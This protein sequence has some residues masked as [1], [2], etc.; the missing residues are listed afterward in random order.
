MRIRHRLILMAALPAMLASVILLY[1]WQVM[2]GIVGNATN[3]FDQRITPV[4]LLTG[5]SRTYAADVVD[6][7]HQS[8]AQMLMWNDAAAQLSKARSR[9]EQDWQTYLSADLSAAEQTAIANAADAPQQALAVIEKLQ[10]YVAEHESYSMGGYIDMDLYPQLTPM[11]TLIDQL[12]SIQTTLADEGKAD[13]QSATRAAIQRIA[14]LSLVTIGIMAM[15]GFAGYRKILTPLRTIRNQVI[16]V[17]RQRDLTLRITHQSPDELGELARA[18]NNMMEAI[19]ATLR[20]IQHSGR[21]VNETGSELLAL[22]L[23]TGAVAREQ[24]QAMDNTNQEI[25]RVF[26]ASLEVRNASDAASEQTIK[27]TALVGVGDQKVKEV[28]EAISQS[29]G[30]IHSSVDNAR[31]LLEHSGH[32]GT[33]LDV[34]SNIAAQT[35]LLALNAA[36]EAA[37]A[38]E[39]GRGFAV[40]ADEVRTLAQRTADSTREIQQLVENIQQG[41]SDTAAG[42]E[43]LTTLSAYMVERAQEAGQSLSDI[44]QAVR[45]LQQNSQ[46]VQS[47]TGEQLQT[48][49][50]IQSQS[51]QV[52][53]QCRTT[54]DKALNTE[55]LSHTLATLAGEQERSLQAF[56]VG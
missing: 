33:V 23:A 31:S 28:V 30:Q 5:I 26:A 39:H 24:V 4:R 35:N 18:F 13:A 34:I 15:L 41:A 29:S 46:Q 43:A 50:K 49:Q 22:A 55:Q 6:V 25:S 32:I 7:A 19:A 9:I 14:L 8:R 56:R 52:M 11:L 17:E 1:I 16:D 12:V 36:I 44:R 54:A 42:L 51:D 3:L 48:S 10:G 47:L 45:A 38:G 27:A 40:V 21:Q 53:A 2:P 20:D 37:R